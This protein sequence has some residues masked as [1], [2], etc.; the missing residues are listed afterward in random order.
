MAG[1]EGASTGGRG[2]GVIADGTDAGTGGVTS[3]GEAILVA[4]LGVV[5]CARVEAGDRASTEVGLR[6]ANVAGAAAAAP[7]VVAVEI[8]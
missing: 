8:G 4:G 3:G 5:I 7:E 6:G 1:S 2:A